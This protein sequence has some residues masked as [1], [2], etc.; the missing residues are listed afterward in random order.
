MT[1][2]SVYIQKECINSLLS[3][4]FSHDLFIY[5]NII[6]SFLCFNP[7]S[8]SYRVIRANYN[9]FLIA[10]RENLPNISFSMLKVSSGSIFKIIEM[11]IRS[12]VVNQRHPLCTFSE[13]RAS[14]M[15]GNILFQ[16]KFETLS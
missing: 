4:S 7:F 9:K 13:T 11:E 2:F 10:D 1:A 8:Y 5:T 16:R 3:Q 15:E 6:I 12:V 14:H